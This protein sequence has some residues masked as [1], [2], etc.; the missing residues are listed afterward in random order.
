MMPGGSDIV[1]VIII[2]CTS[3]PLAYW[4][5]SQLRQTRLQTTPS[6]TVPEFRF[7]LPMRSPF[8][9]YCGGPCP[10]RRCAP[11]V[12]AYDKGEEFAA[13]VDN[14]QTRTA[15]G[16]RVPAAIGDFL[17]LR[18]CRESNGCVELPCVRTVAGSYSNA[19]RRAAAG[20]RHRTPAHRIGLLI[21]QRPWLEGKRL[22]IT[23]HLNL[24]LACY[25]N[26][27]ML[28]ATRVQL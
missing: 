11:I 26:F 12:N 2:I 28:T 27:C 7:W 16:I 9:A 15:M 14:A 5:S 21:R 4:L 8:I 1:I 18:A 10:R 22:C 20:H 23:L 3:I 6:R 19:L 13:R 25:S 17:I 24:G